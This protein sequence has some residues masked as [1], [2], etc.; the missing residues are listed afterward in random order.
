METL[1]KLY[2]EISRDSAMAAIAVRNQIKG[3][4]GITECAKETI[5]RN[6]KIMDSLEKLVA[7]LH[8][9]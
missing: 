6:T 8:R 7:A 2:E 4:I 1:L 3:K 5:A 9:R